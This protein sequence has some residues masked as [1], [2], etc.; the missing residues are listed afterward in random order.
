MERL[1]LVNNIN[2]HWFI[3][4]EGSSGYNPDTVEIELLE[5]EAAAG[6]GRGNRGLP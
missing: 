2:L 1:S 3:T 5:Q 4:G 6:Q